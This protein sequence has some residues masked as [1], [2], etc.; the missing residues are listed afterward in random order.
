MLFFYQETEDFFMK[1]SRHEKNVAEYYE[2]IWREFVRWWCSGETL[3]L[4]YAFYENGVK[5]FKEAVYNMNEFIG[6]LLCL[7][8]K[9][10]MKILDAGCGV[11]GTSIYLAKKYPKS[12][13][14]GVS[15]TPG[16]IALAKKFAKE[17]HIKNVTF[18][19][20]SYLD[21]GVSDRF[22]DGVFALESLGYSRD[23]DGFVEEMHRVLKPGGRL[24]VVDGFRTNVL[25][26]P[27]MQKFYDDLRIGR[28]YLDLPP[29]KEYQSYLEKRGFIDVTV[30][31]ISK[32][33]SRSQW[34]SFLI[35]IPYFV[36]TGIKRI[37]TLRRYDP[38]EDFVN[39]S[40]G[41]AV[42]CSLIGFSGVSRYCAVIAVK[43]KS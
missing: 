40:M 34:R 1:R 31:D 18:L 23:I 8:D 15:V 9:K 33:V 43:K 27:V 36:Y 38:T 4:H 42:R 25:M 11:G 37:V 13:F 39:Y 2:D 30:K 17:R 32:N 24:V 26:N 29:L 22:F 6:R 20:S 12:T 41:T 3:G 35:G 28:G 5:G 10:S 19:L 21:T 7:D 14:T 16:Q